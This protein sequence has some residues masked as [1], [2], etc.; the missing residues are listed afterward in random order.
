MAATLR[1]LSDPELEQL[2][3]HFAHAAP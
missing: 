3:H 1:G 2:A